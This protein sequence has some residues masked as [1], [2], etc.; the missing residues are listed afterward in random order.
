MLKF[1]F[2]IKPDI[3]VYCADSTPS[4]PSTTDSRLAEIFIEFKW[5]AT[6]DPFCRERDVKCSHCEDRTVRSFLRESSAG[7]DTLGQ[8]T[9]YAVAQLGSQFRTH[10][11]SV[12]VVEGTARIL[13]WDRSGTI[14]TEAI[15]YNESPLLAEFFRRYSKAPP[16]M[17]GKDQS[18]SAVTPIEADAARRALELDNII[19]LVKLAIPA[20]D[21]SSHYFITSTPYAT[22]YTPPGRATRG[23]RAYDSS[24]KTTVFLKDSWRI[25]LP[26]I[27]AEGVTYGILEHKGVRNIPRC[28]VSGDISSAEYH[29]TKT[30]HYFKELWACHAHAQFL[31]HRH[32]RLVLDVVGHSL[33]EFKS[34]YEMVAAVR[35][36]IV[37][38]LPPC[39]FSGVTLRC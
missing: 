12:F 20:T 9:S 22:L 1:P 16:E 28:L 30:R 3:S 7:D 33:T 2:K 11:Y 36:A 19:P 5:N 21:G 35:D 34:S 24:Q 38:A 10:L 6:D 18:V 39:N 29:A 26:D 15:P 14:V 17:R 25:D 23:F 37:G 4:P 27:P 31:P 13:R 32:Y 8:I